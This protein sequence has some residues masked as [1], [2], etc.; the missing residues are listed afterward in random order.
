MENEKMQRV[1][2]K[3]RLAIWNTAERA[4]DELLRATE[5]TRPSWRRLPEVVSP[6]LLPKKSHNLEKD[7]AET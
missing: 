6:S 1:V 5:R 4:L 3:T 7:P 2:V